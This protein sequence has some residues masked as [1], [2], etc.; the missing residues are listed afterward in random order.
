MN[1]LIDDSW[2]LSLDQKFASGSGSLNDAVQ[3]LADVIDKVNDLINGVS[4]QEQVVNLGD[5]E[6][7]NITGKVLV[8]GLSSWYSVGEG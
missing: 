5:N 8:N 4:I 1:Q 3:R 2:Q 6:F 7:T